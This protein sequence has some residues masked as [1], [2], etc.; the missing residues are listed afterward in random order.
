[1]YSDTLDRRIAALSYR[2]AP[3][4]SVTPAAVD[5]RWSPDRYAAR[6]RRGE[7]L[8]GLGGT[9]LCY[10]LLAAVVLWRWT[11]TPPTPSSRPA[12]AL[13]VFD[14]P[15][16][17]PPSPITP[18]QVR[19]RPKEA[20]QPEKTPDPL[21]I[22][23]RPSLT[24]MASASPPSSRSSDELP[25]AVNEPIGRAAPASPASIAAPPIQ[26]NTAAAERAARSNWE[27]DLLAQ[28]RPLL[29]YPRAAQ[30]DGQQGVALVMI[31]VARDGAVRSARIV[32]G[33]GYPLLDGEALATIRR[34]S[35]LP[36]P[37]SD[38]PGDPVAVE[39]PIQFS[40]HG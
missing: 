34:G 25:E 38:I 22:V 20:Q 14:V 9:A 10:A 6:H 35:P 17:G 32:R 24:T 2:S 27:G 21:P 12:P 1:M 40:L 39:L 19:F 7:T 23:A 11:P 30:R 3:A 28:L 8:L 16:A 33:T 31:S 29:R 26:G 18:D 13:S 15:P 36:P 37:P 5:P 4:A